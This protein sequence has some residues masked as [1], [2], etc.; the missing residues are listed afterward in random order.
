MTHNPKVFQVFNLALATLDTPNTY[1]DAHLAAKHGGLHTVSQGGIHSVPSRRERAI[2][3]KR[4]HEENVISDSSSTVMS[5]RTAIVP[6]PP[7][8]Q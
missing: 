6:S 2:T 3:E 4:G 8:R 1:S 7:G 5:F